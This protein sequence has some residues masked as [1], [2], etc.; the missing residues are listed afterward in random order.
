MQVFWIFVF[1]LK[2]EISILE[3]VNYE[4]IQSCVKNGYHFI[5][6]SNINNTVQMVH[7]YKYGLQFE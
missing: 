3:Q 4:L 7:L 2:V 5:D 6:N 1:N